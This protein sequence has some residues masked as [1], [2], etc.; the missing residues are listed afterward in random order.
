MQDLVAEKDFFDWLRHVSRAYAD[1]MASWGQRVH[2]TVARG[3]PESLEALIA[4]TDRATDR[5][6]GILMAIGAR[7]DDRRTPAEGHPVLDALD[8]LIGASAELLREARSGIERQGVQALAALSARI[9]ELRSLEADVED[10]SKRLS[11]RVT[12]SYGRPPEG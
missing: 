3:T 2:D 12:D 4:E 7:H 9:V 11:G 5:L 6:V 1:A 8:R 10:A